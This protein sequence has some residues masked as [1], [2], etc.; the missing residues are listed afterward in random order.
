MSI[1]LGFLATAAGKWIV[2][3]L[4]V[5]IAMLGTYLKG[6]LSGAKAER[7]KQAADQLQAVKDRK[8]K[9]DEI[10]SLGPASLD[11]R[12]SEWLRDKQR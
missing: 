6:R 11:S 1:L 12:L 7:D 4:A 3:A 10:N 9:D 8:E 5:V 2:G